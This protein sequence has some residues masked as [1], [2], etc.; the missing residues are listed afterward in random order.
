MSNLI[1]SEL[2]RILRKVKN[3]LDPEDAAEE[4]AR[5]ITKKILH[6]IICEL[7]KPQ[8]YDIEKDKREYEE[9]YIKKYSKV[10]DHMNDA[11]TV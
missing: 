2:D 10:A 8:E 6:P 1:D 4:L 3:G 11:D 7:K 9:N 5:R